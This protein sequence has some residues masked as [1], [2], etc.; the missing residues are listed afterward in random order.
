MANQPG[1]T[2]ELETL[3]CDDKTLRGSITATPSGAARFN[4]QVS[5]YSQSLGVAIAQTT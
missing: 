4:A 2:A 5:L 1:V 3:V